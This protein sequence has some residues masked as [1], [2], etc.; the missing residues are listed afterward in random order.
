MLAEPAK[1]VYTGNSS[2]MARAELLDI[3]LQPKGVRHGSTK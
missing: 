2:A 1:N 3:F